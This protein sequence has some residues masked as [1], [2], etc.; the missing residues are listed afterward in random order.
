VPLAFSWSRELDILAMIK[1]PCCYGNWA[2]WRR[3]R[4]WNGSAERFL[5]FETAV[6]REVDVGGR[7]D[8]AISSC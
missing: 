6:V 2:G 4:I 1:I 7:P 5:W 3:R 8:V